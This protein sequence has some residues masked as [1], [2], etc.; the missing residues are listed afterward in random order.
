MIGAC[1]EAHLTIQNILPAGTNIEPN[2]T[3]MHVQADNPLG[4]NNFPQSR[5]LD[6]PLAPHFTK[7]ARHGDP[8]HSHWVLSWDAAEC[9]RTTNANLRPSIIVAEIPCQLAKKNS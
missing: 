6:S 1:H 4:C 9:V 8:G 7:N 3:A 2:T 5:I